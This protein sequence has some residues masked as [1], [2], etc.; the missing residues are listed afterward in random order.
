MSHTRFY[1]Y[2]SF[3]IAHGINLNHFYFS[4]QRIKEDFPQKLKTWRVP[5]HSTTFSTRLWYFS[6]SE[7][8]TN[9]IRCCWRCSYKTLCVHC[10]CCSSCYFNF[11]SPRQQLRNFLYD[12]IFCQLS[13]G[14]CRHIWYKA[15]RRTNRGMKRI[16]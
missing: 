1:F 12:Y 7:K 15:V 4:S 11:F 14:L 13:C 16:K 8:R 9:K 5:L 10:C 3:D 2:F 6:P